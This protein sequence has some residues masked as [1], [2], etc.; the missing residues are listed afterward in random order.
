MNGEEIVLGIDLATANARIEAVHAATGTVLATK[1]T[2]LTPPVGLNGEREQEPT[3][4]SSTRALL[5]AVTAELGDRAR[6]IRALSITGTSGTIVPTDATGRPVSNALMYND[7]RGGDALAHLSS[8]D[9][10]TAQISGRPLGGLG[11]IAWLQEHRPGERYLH[12]ADVVIAG[13]ARR[14]LATDTSHALKSGI[15]PEAATWP[16]E[17]LKLLGVPASALPALVAPATVIGQV[18]DLVAADLGLPFGVT[19]VA[20]MTDGCT[21]QL[22]TGATRVGDTVGTLGT[23]LVLKG[24]ANCA[25]AAPD[26]GV[27]SHLAPDKKYWTGGASNVGAGSL[28]PQATAPGQQVL[29]WNRRAAAHG[30]ARQVRYPLTGTGERFPFARPNARGFTIQLGASY[31]H[32]DVVDD[33]RAVHE[34][35]AFVERLG[36]ETLARLGQ[37]LE[38][39]FVSGGASSSLIWNEIRASVLARPLHIP[40]HRSSAYGAAILAAVGLTGVDTFHQTVDR[41][42]HIEGTCDPNTSLIAPLEERY[43]VFTNRLVELGY[44]S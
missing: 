4:C 17:A 22:A 29:K 36:L 21:A 10:A 2:A 5:A 16:C 43:R 24:V 7:S 9:A 35:V 41:M 13:L 26:M 42:A 15:D 20:G 40:A 23:T 19:I 34:G 12:T 8:S 14:I 11:R 25:L 30:P 32:P 6:H 27:Y 1:T 38:R 37:P 3:Y 44:A 28:P 18:A 39:H 33:Y 31:T